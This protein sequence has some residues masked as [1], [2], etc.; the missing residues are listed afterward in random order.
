MCKSIGIV[1]RTWNQCVIINDCFFDIHLLLCLS[2]NY[3]IRSVSVILFQDRKR[4]LEVLE[5]TLK[6]CP[7]GGAIIECIYI[8]LIK[9]TLTFDSLQHVV[10]YNC[11]VDIYLPTSDYLFWY[12]DSC[13]GSCRWSAKCTRLSQ[14]SNFSAEFMRL[15]SNSHVI[16][17]SHSIADRLVISNH[18]QWF[19]NR[20]DTIFNVLL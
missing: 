19:S 12:S 8:V 3:S 14:S 15:L 6:E 10:V 1:I 5:K 7:D 4:G 17:Q 20:L 18:D 16:R 13:L 9:Y 2:I 11:V